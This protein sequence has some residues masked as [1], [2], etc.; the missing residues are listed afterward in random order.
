M[1]IEMRFGGSNPRKELV[2]DLRKWTIVILPIFDPIHSI[3]S[4]MFIREETP[5][6]ARFF[7]FAF[8]G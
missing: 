2:G 7:L 3:G 8:A 6:K 5:T 1:I 4:S